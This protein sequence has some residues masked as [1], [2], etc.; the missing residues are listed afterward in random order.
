MKILQILPAMNQGGVEYY[1]LENSQYIAQYAEN[2]VISAGG[3]LVPELIQNDSQHYELPIEKKNLRSLMQIRKLRKLIENIHPDIIH[4]HSR[5]QAWLITFALKKLSYRPTVITTVHGFNSINRYS[6]QMLH[7]DQVIAVSE[8]LKK[9]LSQ[10]Y[11]QEPVDNVLVIS[12]GI[13]SNKFNANAPIN[14]SIRQQMIEL[15]VN[16]EYDQ[17]IL[18]PGRIT[19]IKGISL[20]IDLM[21][22]LK[23]ENHSNIKAVIVGGYDKRNEEFYQSMQNRITELQLEKQILWLGTCDDMASIY[24]LADLTLSITSKPESYGRTVIESL[25]CK[26][27]VVGFNYGGVGENL[28]RFYPEGKITPNNLSELHDAVLRELSIPKEEKQI[29]PISDTIEQS[30]AKLKS[31]YE[32]FK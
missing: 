31:L 9:Y 16:F 28:Q 3:R 8:S 10:A 29:H 30:Q 5:L 24:R 11:P 13:D 15:G 25:A 2:F 26:T 4:V 17:I 32:S 1:V 6:Q 23:D 18:L 21:K 22:Q 7:A 27:P 20:L 14:N 19:R 12:Q